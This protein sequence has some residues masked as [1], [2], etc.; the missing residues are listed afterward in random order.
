[1]GEVVYFDAASR[2]SPFSPPQQAQQVPY[3]TYAAYQQA[4]M[5]FHALYFGRPFDTAEACKGASVKIEERHWPTVQQLASTLLRDKS[6]SRE[7]V[8]KL[9]LQA[10]LDAAVGDAEP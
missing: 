4:E 3:E 10:S 7:Q 5:A 9:M 6:L 2:Q 1:M 8:L